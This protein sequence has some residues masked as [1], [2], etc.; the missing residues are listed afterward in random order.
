MK[1]HTET[2]SVGSIAPPFAL[3]AAN[4]SGEVSLSDLISKGLLIIDFQRGT[5]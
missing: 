4:R 3:H 1:N 2:L 5:W